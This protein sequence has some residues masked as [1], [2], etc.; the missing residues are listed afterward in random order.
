M[1]DYPAY[2]APVSEPARDPE[3]PPLL[4]GHE[5]SAEEDALARAV[6]GARGGSFGAGDFVWSR[7]HDVF[8]T[9]LVLEPDIARERAAEI[10]FVAQVA[11]ADCFGAISPPEVALTFGWPMT[12]RLNGGR[13]GEL[14]LVVADA[15]DD[16]GAPMWMVAGLRLVMR[17]EHYHV[18]PGKMPDVTT[19]E[20]EGCGDID[21]VDLV[22]A[23]ARHLLVWIHT[24]SEDGFKP[25]HDNYVFRADGYNEETTITHAGKAHDGTL[26]GLDERGAALM[27]TADGKVEALDPMLAVIREM[28]IAGGARS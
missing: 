1:S 18:D 4:T 17:H 8:D 14:R 26:I 24:W 20:E 19:F 15:D 13:I 22:E 6:A 12:V 27:K 16:D 21:T 11:F 9:A 7:A 23:F 10:A 2:Q 25:V 3:F 5:I 28:D